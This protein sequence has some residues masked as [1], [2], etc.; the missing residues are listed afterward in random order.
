[1]GILTYP[2]VFWENTK[3]F[4]QNLTKSLRQVVGIDN[5]SSTDKYAGVIASLTATVNELTL[6]QTYLTYLLLGLIGVLVI[7]WIIRRFI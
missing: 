2:S 3:T 5:S 6:Q 1:M 7:R 4:F